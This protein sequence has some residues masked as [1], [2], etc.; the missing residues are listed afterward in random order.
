MGNVKPRRQTARE[1]I[2]IRMLGLFLFPANSKRAPRGII[3]ERGFT[4]QTMPHIQLT[5]WL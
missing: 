5:D 3:Y 4:A 1:G 2:L